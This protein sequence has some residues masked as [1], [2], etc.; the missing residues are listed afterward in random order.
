MPTAKVTPEQWQ[1]LVSRGLIDP[2]E[3]KTVHL[4]DEKRT[5]AL[6][7]PAKK[8][9]NQKDLIAA[10]H[11]PPGTW[12]IPVRTDSTV[13]AD[14]NRRTTM[15]KKHSQRLAVH[16][17][18][19]R[20]HASL[21]AFA[22]NGVHAGLPIL[23]TLVRLGGRHLDKDDN[24]NVSMKWVRDAIADVLGIDDDHDLIDWA[25]GQEKCDKV[26]VRVTITRVH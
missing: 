2:A 6:S 13:N 14:S 18:L 26:G 22:D 25:Y 23:V 11:M 5:N 9:K 15:S 20:N 8:K 3:V 4:P 12:L 7:E 1:D 24:L 19:G 17:T 21:V 16:R 10:A